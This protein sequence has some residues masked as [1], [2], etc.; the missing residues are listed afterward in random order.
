MLSQRKLA[1][2]SA[3]PELYETAVP[4]IDTGR[5]AKVKRIEFYGV[6]ILNF[7]RKSESVCVFDSWLS[8]LRLFLEGTNEY[9]LLIFV[10]IGVF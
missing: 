4:V 2:V 6:V 3:H 9:H 10:I 8:F 5:F 1:K 7:N